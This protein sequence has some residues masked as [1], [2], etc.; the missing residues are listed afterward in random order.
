MAQVAETLITTALE[1]KRQAAFHRR[2]MREVFEELSKLRM[3]AE[4]LGFE[5]VYQRKGE[6]E[7]TH[8]RQTTP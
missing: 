8:G 5:L 3:S 4:A 2:R 6:G 7:K 1:H